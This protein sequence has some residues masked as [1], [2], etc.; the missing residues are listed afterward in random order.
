[1]LSKS[2]AGEEIARELIKVLSITYSIR[3]INL[4]AAMR[5][6]AATNNVA[7]HT[8]KIVSVSLGCCFSHTIDHVG[9]HFNTPTLSEFISLWISLFS[10]SP[11]THLL[12]KSRTG[13]S[14]SRYSAT[15]WW[16][17]WEVVKQ[18]MVY[19]GDIEP[20]LEENED[21]GPSL[22][23]KLLA[24]FHT[25]QTKSKLQIEIAATVDWG[26]PF[27]KACYDLEGDGPLA[28]ECYERVDRV[29]ASIAT[30]NIPNVRATAEKL[31]R[32]PPSHPHH[33][34]WVT[35]ARSSVKDGLDYIQ[36]SVSI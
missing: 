33:E 16:S 3:P 34:Q 30:E 6:R 28:F 36:T 18:V 17:K 1:M 12:W 21:I 27:V 14:M 13:Q 23:P 25:S 24:F 15:R 9:S 22:R 7:M 29:L 11:K 2:L 31:T 32:Q 10:H 26:E 19:F 5:H 8:L 4:L 20:F 35:Y